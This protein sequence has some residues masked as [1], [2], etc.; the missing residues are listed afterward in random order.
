MW[1]TPRRYRGETLVFAIALCTYAYFHQGGGWSQNIRFAQVRAIVE[2][3]S[4]AVDSYL[5]YDVD[6]SRR[7]DC[8]LRRVPVQDGRCDYE[9]RNRALAW[10]D[11]HGL[12][13]AIDERIVGD[14]PLLVI[15][16]VAVS[17]DLAYSCGHFF[18]NKAPGPSFLAV[19]GYALLF[20]LERAAGLDP[21]DWWILTV[22]AWLSGV[23]S[24]G[25]VSAAGCLLFYWLACDLSGGDQRVS[26]LA[27][28]AFAGGT[29]FFPY[30]TMLHEHNFVAVG[31]L[32]GF[33]C[34]YRVKHLAECAHRRWLWLFVAGVSAG[35]AA[36][37]N[38]VAAGVVV[39]LGFYLLSFDRAARSVFAYAFGVLMPFLAL[40]AYHGACFGKPFTTGYH[41]Q[42]PHFLAGEGNFLGVFQLPRG[43]ILTALLL[44]PYRGLFFSSPVLLMGVCGWICLRRERDHR[45][46]A[47]LF[48][49]IVAFFLLLNSA[50]NG[51][52]GGWAA[53]PRYLVPAVPFLGLSLVLACKRYFRVTSIL[54]G[55]SAVF[56][57]VTTA[58][59]PQCPLGEPGFASV[60]GRA[61]W[62]YCPLAEYEFPLFLR[63]QPTSFLRVQAS[64]RMAEL[65]EQYTRTGSLPSPYQGQALEA[66]RRSLEEAVEG[67]DPDV[68]ALAAI[69]GPVSANRQGVYEGRPFQVLP[70]SDARTRWNSFNVGEFFVPGDRLSLLPLIIAVGILAT[71]AVRTLSPRP[72]P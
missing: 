37:C 59:D 52:P 8:H 10:R 40:C 6:P 65:E 33:Y 24:G 56:M 14:A 47:T 30:A 25:L 72:R 4:L 69:R 7:E 51:W 64:D 67:G 41:F 16:Q 36:A 17:G 22:N 21:D 45:A 27:T 50:F 60:A 12:P 35:M 15:D 23:L 53:G 13:V 2:E 58:V 71:I 63:G 38:Y 3:G 49:A 5:I 28:A 19:P 20:H 42:N 70:A 46:E 9:G 39:F 55:V 32:G 31:L 11:N 48:L 34:L 1:S 43:E 57:L 29:L 66:V 61:L 18:P 54:A 62:W 26:L 44:S 68:F